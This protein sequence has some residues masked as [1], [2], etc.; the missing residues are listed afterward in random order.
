MLIDAEV[1]PSLEQELL[2]RQPWMHPFRFA[3]D[4]IVGWFKHEV[5]G[6]ATACVSSSP[7]NLR[8]SMAAAFDR[9]MAA[10]PEYEIRELV[11]RVGND[12]RYLDIACATGWHSLALADLGVHEVIGVEIRPEQVGNAEF[13]RQLE[14]RRFAAARFEHEPVSADDS[15]FR[16]D[17]QY[18]VVLSLG[19]LYH[20]VDPFTHLQNLRR[21]A[22]RAVLLKTLTHAHERGFW[23]HV[24][25]DPRW[26]TKAWS[27]ASW[28]PHYADVPDLLRAV[29]FDAV[30]TVTR[31][32]L[33][34]PHARDART[35]SRLARLI[36]PG[37]VFSIRGRIDA[38]AARAER[39]GVSSRYYTYLAR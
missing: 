10:D 36:L 21:L 3:D 5:D 26:M 25:E 28:I 20:L 11:E 16:A 4:V 19:L 27:A 7:P 15:D 23:M 29:G 34:R 32:E 38:Q 39:L 31:P 33:R 13:I 30:E 9:H 6:D 35:E 8:A 17:E 12:G 14:P 18:D 1:T 37:A 24:R 2:S 22:K